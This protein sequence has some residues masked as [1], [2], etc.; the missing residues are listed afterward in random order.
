MHMGTEPGKSTLC[1]FLKQTLDMSGDRNY[2]I[3]F[4]SVLKTDMYWMHVGTETGKSTLCKF[5][6]QTLGVSGAESI[7]STS[8][9]FLKQNVMDAC[10]DRNW[11]IDIV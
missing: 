9:Q 11:K 2:K 4:V 5:L 1:K 7:N 6:K 8:C 3:N 10:G